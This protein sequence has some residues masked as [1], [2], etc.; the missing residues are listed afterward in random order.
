METKDKVYCKDCKYLE[1]GIEDYEGCKSCQNPVCFTTIYDPIE[2]P[3]K[4]RTSDC[5][6]ENR[7]CNCQ[8]FEQKEIKTKKKWWRFFC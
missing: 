6:Q 4:T 2:G 3:T 1:E 8:F 7:D 5:K